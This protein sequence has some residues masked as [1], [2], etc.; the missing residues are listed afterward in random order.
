VLVA[1]MAVSAVTVASASGAVTFLPAEWLV[2]GEKVAAKLAATA[3]GEILL[4]DTNALKAGIKADALCSGILDGTI[5][6]GAADEITELLTL[7]GVAVPKTA[8]EPSGLACTNDSNCESAKAWAINLPWLTE[9]Q[10]WEEGTE[11]GFVILISA[12]AGGAAPGWYVECTVLGVKATDECKAATPESKPEGATLAE[13]ETGGVLTEFLESFTE[14]ME[15]KL[16]LC[17]SSGEE[18]GIVE[19]PGLEATTEGTLTI[20]SVT[21]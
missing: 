12:H 10:L 17:S 3:T 11:S 5:G 4:E 9:V 8:L 6:P 15:L 16:A 21:P 1:M 18:T 14:L 20:S 2:N 19:G 7:A 13:N